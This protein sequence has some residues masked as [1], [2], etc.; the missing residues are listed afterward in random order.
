MSNHNSG[1]SCPIC[2]AGNHQQV[3]IPKFQGDDKGHIWCGVCRASYD[4]DALSIRDIKVNQELISKIDS[5]E[6]YRK[7]FVETWEIGTEKGEVYTDFDW[8]DN[9]VLQEGV[10]AHVVNSI[11]KYSSS[12][13]P[14]ILDLGCGNGFTTEILGREFGKE[15]VIG[16]DPSPMILQLENR[17]G[18]KGLQGTLDS[19]RF[20]DDMFD[21]VVIIGNLMLHSNMAST[22]LE[23]HRILKPGGI[24]VID[25]KNISSASRVLSRWMVKGGQKFSNNSMVQ[26][27]FLNMRYGLS[28]KHIPTIAPPSHFEVLDTYDKPPRLLEFGNKSHWQSN[29]KGLIWRGLNFIDSLRGEQAW[30]QVTMRKL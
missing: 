8:D 19:I 13:K 20:D 11:R 16:A 27:N 24:A 12:K 29:L 14:Y 5:R 7:L 15:N 4:S 6:D 10:A 26:R 3:I 23:A 17:T 30:I 25:F 2:N 1:K 22:L 28:K 9:K 21:T 18:V